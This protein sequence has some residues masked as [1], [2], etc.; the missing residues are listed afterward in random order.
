MNQS[1]LPPPKPRE[2]TINGQRYKLVAFYYPDRDTPWDAVYHGQ[3]LGNFYPCSMTLTINGLTAS[4]FNAEAAFQATKWWH[5][6]VALAQFQGAKTGTQ[7]FH[8]K[9]SL[10]NPDYRYAGLERDGA[11]QKVL[12]QKFNDPAF[13]QALLLTEDAYLLEHNEMKGRDDYWSDDHDGSGANMLGKTLMSIRKSLGG[14]A[15]PAGNYT[16][17]EFTAQVET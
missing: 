6:P 11:M 4:F 15:A 12:T 16:V 10:T 5:N 14:A 9:K 8:I 13:K 2:I 3:F 7:A 17:A 1:F